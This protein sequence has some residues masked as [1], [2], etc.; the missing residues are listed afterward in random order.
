M[1]NFFRSDQFKMIRY[2]YTE[3]ELNNILKTMKIVVDSREQVNGHILEYF[4]ARMCQS[5]YKK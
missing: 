5:N 1:S 2:Q 3:T 4:A